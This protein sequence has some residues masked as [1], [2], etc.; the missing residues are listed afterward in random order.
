MVPVGIAV[1]AAAGIAFE[2]AYVLQALE[3][4]AAPALAR[5]AGALA[6]LLRRPRWLAGLALAGLGA[7]LQVV[8]LRLAPL[9]VVQPTLAIGIVALVGVG[10]KVLGEPAGWRRSR[11]PAGSRCS[12]SPART[13]ARR[14]RAGSGPPS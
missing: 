6:G 7:I 10:G 4:R 14:R 13:S 9:T 8:A 11:S 12:G 3:A 5:P 1:A 2:V